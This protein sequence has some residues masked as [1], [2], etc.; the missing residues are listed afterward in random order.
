MARQGQ[1]ALWTLLELSV[2]RAGAVLGPALDTRRVALVVA[3]CIAQASGALTSTDTDAA[4]RVQKGSRA[5]VR[6]RPRR[7]PPNFVVA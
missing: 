5:V 4:P 2:A 3:Q 7:G 6:S 1:R